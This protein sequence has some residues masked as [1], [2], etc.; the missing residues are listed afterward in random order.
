MPSR[1]KAKSKNKDYQNMTGWEGEGDVLLNGTIVFTPEF[2]EEVLERYDD[3]DPDVT[4]DHTGNI[5]LRF[6]LRESEYDNVDAF[7]SVYIGTAQKKK[8]SSRT[9]SR[10]AKRR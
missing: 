9:K 4:D 3:Q 10:S 1:S 7:G 6:S 2:L 5:K 8:S